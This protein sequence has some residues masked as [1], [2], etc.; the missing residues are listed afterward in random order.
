MEKK[1]LLSLNGDDHGVVGARA[2]CLLVADGLRLVQLAHGPQHVGGVLQRVGGGGA[3]VVARRR[4]DVG[5]L[6]AE[7][8]HVLS[9]VTTAAATGGMGRRLRRRLFGL[10]LRVAFIPINTG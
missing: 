3:R 4:H 9:T 10:V 7:A 5:P 2:E 6:P 8:A 1:A